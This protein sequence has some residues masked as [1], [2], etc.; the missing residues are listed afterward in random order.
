MSLLPARC[1]RFP[2]LLARRSLT[3]GRAS[4]R[5]YPA[6]ML[7]TSATSTGVNATARGLLA[8]IGFS[9]GAG[10]LAYGAGIIELPSSS[11]DTKSQYGSHEDVQKAISELHDAFRDKNQVNTDPAVVKQYG[12]SPNSYHPASPHSISAGSICI[13]M[14]AM[15]KILRIDG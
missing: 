11:T 8:G 5:V 15:D 10:L 13:D 3:S 12:S 2:T 4:A 14:S 7:S 1:S 9:L 6:R